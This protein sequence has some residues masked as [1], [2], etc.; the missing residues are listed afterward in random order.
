M[1]TSV[2]Y[3]SVLDRQHYI[4]PMRRSSI[5]LEDAATAA[6]NQ[7]ALLSS[8]L[9]TTKAISGVKTVTYSGTGST[10]ELLVGAETFSITN[11]ARST[12]VVT[13]TFS[14]DPT[15]KVAVGDIVKVTA[16]TNTSING[17]FPVKTV[18]STGITYDQT[19][20]TIA[21]G[22]DTGTVVNGVYPLNGTGRPIMLN[23]ITGGPF[24]T[25]TNTESVITDDQATLGN[26]I[27]ISLTDSRSAAIKGMTVHRNVDHKILSVLDTFSTTEQLGFKYLRVGPGGTTEK[28]LCYG[29]FS[30]ISEDGDSGTLAKFTTTLTVIGGVYKILDNTSG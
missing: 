12:G 6:A 18:T 3:T 24:S 2:A 23:N 10:F 22:A 7:G 27:T 17:T 16:V 11:V 15:G 19:G 21:S 20:A 26:A 5:V 28:L 13:L 4:V 29:M 30:S 1:A 9:D 8:W 14:A 25:S